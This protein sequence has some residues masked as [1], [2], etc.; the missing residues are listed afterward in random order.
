MGEPNNPHF[1]D[2]WIFGHVPKPQNQLF[3]SLETPGYLNKTKKNH[4][5]I[6]QTYYLYKSQ[7]FEN[8]Q[9]WHSSKRRTAKHDE[10]LT[11]KNNEDP[12]NKILRI[13][14]M[15]S[16]SSRKHEMEIGYSF[17]TKKPRN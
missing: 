4:W 17:E 10:D 13:L 12:F 2:F 15:R 5:N 7:N 1:Y 14:D 11:P 3:L 8:P 6:F 16:I 9:F